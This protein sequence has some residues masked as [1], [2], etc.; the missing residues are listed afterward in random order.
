M[1]SNGFEFSKSS[2]DEKLSLSYLMWFR[3]KHMGDIKL[4]GNTSAKFLSGLRCFLLVH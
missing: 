3:G 4:I 1:H 2:S